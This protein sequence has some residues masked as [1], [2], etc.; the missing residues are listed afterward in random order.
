MERRTILLGSLICFLLGL[1]LLL[2]ANLAFSPVSSGLCEISPGLVSTTGIFRDG[3]LED[4]CR[5][6]LDLPS[7][8]PGQAE[9]ISVIGE[10]DGNSIRVLQWEII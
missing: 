10:Y 8:K 1:S 9:H 7:S 5:V 6:K 3:Y 4:G 2:W